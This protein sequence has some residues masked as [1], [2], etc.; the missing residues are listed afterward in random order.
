MITRKPF[1][2][3]ASI[4]AIS[5]DD[6]VKSI[7]QI[8]G[9]VHRPGGYGVDL[10]TFLQEPTQ[11]DLCSNFVI[12]CANLGKQRVSENL[13]PRDRA[14]WPAVPWFGLCEGRKIASESIPMCLPPATIRL[15]LHGPG[16]MFDPSL[17]GYWG[18]AGFKTTMDAVLEVICGNVTRVDG[19]KI[20]L[21]DK[22]KEI[23]MRRRL[24]ADEKMYTGDD[25]NDPELIEG[26]AQGHSHALL[27][28]LDPPAPVAAAAVTHRGHGDRNAFRDIL[29]PTVPLARL[30]FRAPMQ[31]Y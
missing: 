22:D 24:P 11:N 26:D 2:V 8:G 17:A 30:I 10:D 1:A 14:I 21:L 20:S 16:E 18:A 5:T 27:G 13:A 6:R 4:R 7:S 28:T 9:D 23:R 15:I 19:I 12:A 3:I 31:Y 29:D 25:F